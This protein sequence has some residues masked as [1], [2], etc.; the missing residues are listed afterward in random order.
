MQRTACLFLAPSMCGAGGTWPLFTLLLENGLS[1]SYIPQWMGAGENHINLKMRIAL[2][3]LLLL[4]ITII[5]SLI[6]FP[7]LLVV[8][9]YFTFQYYHYYDY[10]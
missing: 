1:S 3:L 5:L 6:I 4:F 2:L 7:L 10:W 9:Y 8:L